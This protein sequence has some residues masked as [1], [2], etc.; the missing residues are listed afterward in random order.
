[1]RGLWVRLPPLAFLHEPAGCHQL[2]LQRGARFN[3]SP[4]PLPACCRP[5]APSPIKCSGNLRPNRPKAVLQ[6]TKCL[7]SNHLFLDAKLRLFASNVRPKPPICVQ[8]VSRYGPPDTPACQLN[9]L[10]RNKFH[11]PSRTDRLTRKSRGVEAM[12][13]F[14]PRL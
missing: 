1:M 5:H 13:R 11:I 4:D 12:V 8:T 7:R 6:A 3:C 14:Q 2:S 9:S 10:I